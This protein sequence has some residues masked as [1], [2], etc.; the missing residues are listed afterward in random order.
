MELKPQLK[1]TFFNKI[2][3]RP[4]KKNAIIDFNNLLCKPIEIQRLPL[5]V[6]NIESKYKTTLSQEFNLELQRILGQYLGKDLI[7]NTKNDDYKLLIEMFPLKEHEAKDIL[8]LALKSN[9]DNVLKDDL[10]NAIRFEKRIN[11]IIDFSVNKTLSRDI[12]S[13]KKDVGNYIL[14]KITNQLIKEG[15]PISPDV[16]N[17]I[18]Q[19]A[20]IFD[21]EWQVSET[22]LTS[23]NQLKSLW[24][25]QNDEILPE[26]E[27]V[28]LNL[29][30]NE[31]CH[32]RGTCEWK[33]LRK[34]TS[35]YSYA[36][37]TYRFKVAKG[38]YLR[39][40][41][42]AVTRQSEDVWKTIDI[43]RFYFTSHRVVFRGTKGNKTI[44]LNKIL[45]FAVYQ[46]GIALEKDTGKSPF[47]GFD[48]NTTVG[49]AMLGRLIN[50][51]G[52]K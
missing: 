13:R 30:P 11:R 3:G 35:G 40:G 45:E 44:A 48:F 19:T 23:L 10:T 31:T 49:G 21:I 4:N 27:E 18:Y 15:N 52:K 47:I 50:D 39:A 9:I 2:L 16:E 43:G 33:E 17:N 12:E 6:S 42:I 51:H 38:L 7:L 36:G 29:R 26:I 32:F 5:E 46:D 28:E 25:I 37:A 22:D 41:S 1:P 34:E 20:D 24:V 8:I 14:Q